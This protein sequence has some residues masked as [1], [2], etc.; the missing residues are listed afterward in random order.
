[1]KSIWDVLGIAP[2]D[3][4]SAIKKAYS[5]KLRVHHPE[6][7]P[8]GYQ[9]LREAYDQAVKSAKQRGKRPAARELAAA[10]E[11]AD[12]EN[13]EAPISSSP[14]TSSAEERL[15][16][17]E[18]YEEEKE[19]EEEDEGDESEEEENE[20]DEEDYGEFNGPSPTLRWVHVEDGAPDPAEQLQALL[21]RA[22]EIY[23]DFQARL[24]IGKWIELLNSDI[25]WN[26][27]RH[28]IASE[29]MLDF[30]ESRY[31]LPKPVWR[32]LEETFHWKEQATEEEDFEERY[33]HV[34]A[35]AIA[36][37]GASSFGYASLLD[38]AEDT[39]Y[40]G[41]FLLRETAYYTLLEGDYREASLLLEKAYGIFGQDPDL[42][43]LRFE[44]HRLSGDDDRALAVC[45][46]W[47]R[48]SGREADGYYYRGLC[49]LETGRHEEAMK[50]AERL[51][52]IEPDESRAWSLLGKCQFML[53]RPE[54][55][56]K[57]FERLLER[58]AD[59]IEAGIY[60][61]KIR[62][63]SKQHVKVPLRSRLLNGI[64]TLLF[65]KWPTLILLVATH[66]FILSPTGSPNGETP[67]YR[68]SQLFYEPVEET[69]PATI[70]SL[71][72]LNG[73][74]SSEKSPV[75]MTLRD[76]TFLKIYQFLDK[77]EDGSIFTYYMSPDDARKKRYPPTTSGLVWIGE[78]EGDGIV[79]ILSYSK[80]LK[81]GDMEGTFYR[82]MPQNL[83][84][85]IGE[86]GQS[87]PDV[88]RLLRD[89]TLP[90]AYV[91]ARPPFYRSQAPDEEAGLID[92]DI[93]VLVLVLLYGSLGLE[94]RRI[95]RCILYAGNGR[96]RGESR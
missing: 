40:E 26:A 1:L 69:G 59:D 37:S 71:Q 43:R 38:A 67:W 36:E 23:D 62:G 74:Q 64:F 53:G 86:W 32:L 75:I 63:R 6:D 16:E 18:D 54:Q 45:D 31:F 73:L 93:S 33:P 49:L 77:A 94:I 19:E 65:K 11:L 52:A 25:V 70:R 83:R 28:N 56:R 58:N 39:D 85:K 44:C 13:D 80:E 17:V 84:E 96:K 79:A 4:V 61:A 60:L 55:A 91:D 29:E 41:F 2:T 72:E 3:D 34:H 14:E 90:D 47:T 9:R 89:R 92:A 12:R 27:G 10:I 48:V 95:G 21:D 51:A 68:I 7:D 81:A 20:E 35:Y 66:L 46:E 88:R 30:L 87:N 57:T 8:E 42:L 78:L 22:E 15:F 76:A 50:N 82:P 24:D 5:L